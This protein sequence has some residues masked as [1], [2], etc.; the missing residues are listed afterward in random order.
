MRCVLSYEV[1]LID[2]ALKALTSA[3]GMC[4]HGYINGHAYISAFL[5][6]KVERHRTE[7]SMGWLHDDKTRVLNCPGRAVQREAAGTD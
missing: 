4:R 1:V 3:S 5:N 6:N 7:T 2:Y